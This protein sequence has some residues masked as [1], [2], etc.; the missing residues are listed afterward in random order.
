MHFNIV[1][2]YQDTGSRLHQMDARVKFVL[3]VSL[4][5]LVA[6]TPF[7]A[8]PAYVFF[9][10]LIMA[11]AVIARIDPLLVIRR[12]L[13]VLPFAGAAITLIF[14]VPGR[15]IARVPGVGWPIS[16]EGLLRF[17]S[18]LFKS[19]I[20]VM[21]AVILMATTHFTD[22]LWAMGSLRIP[23]ILVAIISFMYRYL[24]VLGDEALRLTRAR[25]SRSA[26]VEGN[27]N[28]GNTLL[29]RARTTGRLIGS[30]FLRSFERSERVYQAMV[31]R[32]YQGEL[33]QL[34]PPRLSVADVLLAALPIGAGIAVLVISLAL[35]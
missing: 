3:A 35:Q 24:F 17:T 8:F 23:R 26:V 1:D 4:I 7:G 12:S 5:L 6:L 9:F 31:A 20:S 32:G 13:V 30:L 18:I 27:T 10:A 21:A 29:F 28:P 22:M 25:D 2:A 16:E 19:L 34:S 11:G 14:T 33:R 15:E